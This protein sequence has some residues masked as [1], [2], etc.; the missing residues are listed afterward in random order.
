[1]DYLVTCTSALL[2]ALLTLFSGFGLGTLLL[3]VFAVFFPTDVAVAA[4]AVVHLA[5]NLFKLLLVGRH[6]AWPVV[7]AFGLPAVPAAIAGALLLGRLSQVPPLASWTLAGRH[8][9]VSV[10]KLVI[11]ALIVVFALLDLLPALK[12]VSIEPRYLPLGGV[13]AGFFGGLSGHQGALRSAFL[14]KA[15][16]TSQQFIATGVVCAVM[17]D[18]AR[19]AVYG[20]EFATRGDAGGALRPGLTGLVVAATLSAFAGSF[21]GARLVKKVTIASIQ[22][23]VGAMLILLAIAL[24][25]GIV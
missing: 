9:E 19:L 10:I 12:R 17:V 25:T 2:I 6:A 8:C 3:P 16:L 20:A 7:L 5:N 1:M 21:I 22:K 23:I 4:T 11:A 18:V 13:L 15:G 24:G 14:L